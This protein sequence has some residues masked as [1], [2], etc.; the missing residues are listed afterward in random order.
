MKEKTRRTVKI[1]LLPKILITLFICIV[2]VVYAVK[3]ED[4]KGDR[5]VVY[6]ARE[7]S[8]VM[9]STKVIS[10][11]SSNGTSGSYDVD[12]E[13]TAEKIIEQADDERNS[14]VLER[15]LGTDEAVQKEF[16]AKLI[17]AE[18]V[19]QYPDLRT[20]DQIGTKIED[21]YEFQG[22]I[23]V[24]R[25]SN[26][27]EGS[28][29]NSEDQTLEYMNYDRFMELVNGNNKDALNY[30]T[31][32]GTANTE[33]LEDGQ[34]PEGT[35]ADEEIELV[36]ATYTQEDIKIT[37]NDNEVNFQEEFENEFQEETND[38]GTKNAT[39][40]EVELDT[41]SFVYQSITDNYTMTFD[42]LWSFLVIGEDIDFVSDL[43]QLALDSKIIITVQDNLQ[44][45][46]DTVN[47]TYQKQID[48][49]IDIK[50]QVKDD[51]TKTD[52]SIFEK[53]TITLPSGEEKYY[54]NSIITNTVNTVVMD[55]TYADTWILE[56][57]NSYNNE[58]N[59]EKEIFNEV[60]TK[61][62]REDLEDTQISEIKEYNSTN[63][64]Q[65]KL[66][67]IVKPFEDAGAKNSDGKTISNWKDE[68]KEDNTQE[69]NSL[70][71]SSVISYIEDFLIDTDYA[72][73]NFLITTYPNLEIKQK[74]AEISMKTNEQEY[75]SARE[76]YVRGSL[77]FLNSSGAT[78]AARV[79]DLTHEYCM[80]FDTEEQEPEIIIQNLKTEEINKVVNKQE[81]V[82]NFVAYNTYTRGTPTV[83]E[84]T[85][86][87]S[88]YSTI[89]LDWTKYFE[90]GSVQEY[91]NGEG[92]YSD[93]VSKY[94]T[95]DK[96]YYICY[97][98]QPL[99]DTYNYGYGLMF[100]NGDDWQIENLRH[101]YKG[102]YGLQDTTAISDETIL[103]EFTENEEKYCTRGDSK[104]EVEIVDNAVFDEY[105]SK[106]KE[107]YTH[108]EAAQEA[109]GGKGLEE[110]T[111]PQ[112]DVLTDRYYNGW[113]N[114]DEHV[115]EIYEIVM[116]VNNGTSGYTMDS[117]ENLIKHGD[118]IYKSRD[119][120]RWQTFSTGEYTICDENG[121]VKKVLNKSEYNEGRDIERDYNFIILMNEHPAAK[122]S[123]ISGA[124][125]L[126]DGLSK[127]PTGSEQIDTIKWL[128]YEL[129]T[130]SSRFDVEDINWDRLLENSSNYKKTQGSSLE[131]FIKA[132]ENY[133]LWQY[134]SGAQS[135]VPSTY[136]QR[137]DGV[138]Y[139]KV[140]NGN[141]ISYNVTVTDKQEGDLIEQSEGQALFEEKVEICTTQVVHYINEKQLE[142][143]RMQEN[144]LIAITYKNGLSYL[145][146]NEFAEKYLENPEGINTSF[147]AFKEDNGENSANY[148]AFSEGEM[149]DPEGNKIKVGASNILEAAAYIQGQMGDYDYCVYRPGNGCD[150]VSGHPCGLPATFEEAQ[151]RGPKN[152]CC[153][154]LVSWV[155]VEAGYDDIMSHVRNRN[156][157]PTMYE[158]L[159]E[160]GEF[161]KINTYGELEPGDIVFM[162]THGSNNGELSH[163]QI[164]AGEADGDH[165]YAYNAGSVRSIRQPMQKQSHS[166]AK[167]GFVCALRMK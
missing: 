110:F 97:G 112:L 37:T 20:K 72:N 26:E 147:A 16:L 69:T 117:C 94:V 151:T 34:V 146:N 161:I 74:M 152:C 102:I 9:K 17:K 77:Y 92:S 123:I 15:Y 47:Y 111:I 167:G 128:L 68:F 153:A 129:T 59:E 73:L 83:R 53:E 18:Y 107:L 2:I 21:L 158:D 166:F 56:Y 39:S 91:L 49:N 58:I 121:N 13:Q 160:T 46:T 23:Q 141:K 63:Y 137:E 61:D 156:Y 50:I 76:S 86:T 149:I 135:A 142:L 55:V 43:A 106:R 3:G 131:A 79:M 105:S 67:A 90:N 124:Q 150:H 154:T 10:T 54:K 33:K 101:L 115:K 99:N 145:E 98:E 48:E 159:I 57:N 127:C 8:Q 75:E 5:S 19:T 29:G 130:D 120:S 38:D 148:L 165:S 44:V 70:N 143:S 89:G 78:Q 82:K 4:I 103:K 40:S 140:Y 104:L 84:K 163:A 139:Y 36:V 114:R 11:N 164:Y 42:M 109:L 32:R 126:F 162:D 27:K 119:N 66:D 28:T 7:H 64:S 85:N 31:L 122:R 125:I 51:N 95:Q 35:E 25:A 1:K 93:Y 116:N 60:Y 155:L 71:T 100:R 62:D 144:V 45:T 133:E 6:A 65:E 108:I 132:W 88:C 12:L 30:F 22:C 96:K 157:P 113:G 136:M 52:E 81:E 24:K 134:E 14:N 118:E 41:T 87:Y 80:Q 138:E